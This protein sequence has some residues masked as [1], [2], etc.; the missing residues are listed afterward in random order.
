M[1]AIDALVR[2]IQTYHSLPGLGNATRRRWSDRNDYA[3]AGG[4]DRN[5]AAEVYSIDS[6]YILCKHKVA[7]SRL[8]T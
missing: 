7:A 4:G 6:V 2:R 8:D 1:K 3:R 5:A